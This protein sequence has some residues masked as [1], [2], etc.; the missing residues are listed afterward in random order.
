MRAFPMKDAIE[1]AVRGTTFP[2]KT[3]AKQHI[4]E[5][6]THLH[7]LASRLVSL[8]NK[9][10]ETNPHSELLGRTL[11]VRHDIE[12]F[13]QQELPELLVEND[14]MFRGY[15]SVKNNILS[16]VAQIKQ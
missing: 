6:L 7:K 12:D 14:M 10:K 2:N 8:N 13:M 11:Y 15:N 1:D 5:M 16:T 9:F 3:S 4:V